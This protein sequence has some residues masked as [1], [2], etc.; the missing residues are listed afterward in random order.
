MRIYQALGIRKFVLTIETNF[1][2]T[3]NLL[4]RYSLYDTI[5]MSNKLGDRNMSK[6]ATKEKIKLDQIMKVLFKLSK[7]VMINLLNGLFDE[8]YDYRKVSIEYSNSEFVD[9]DFE[10]LFGDMFITVRA[11]ES[12]FSYHIEFQTLN[13]NSMAI[14]MFRYGFEKAVERAGYEENEEITLFYPKQLVIFLEENKNIKDEIYF[15]LRLP[16]EQEIRFSVPVMKYWKYSAE[17][18]KDKK[19]YALLPLQVFKSRKKIKSIYDSSIS[20]EDKA[21]LINEEFKGLIVVIENT[22]KV[23]EELYNGEEIICVDLEKILKVLANISE[24]LY[25]KYG[26]YSDIG[27]EVENMVTTLFDPVVKKEVKMEAKA[28]A[29]AEVATNMLKEKMDIDLIVRLTGLTKEEVLKIKKEIELQA[30]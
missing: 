16:Y 2:E 3:S 24:Y 11:N 30:E 14:R 4:S 29:K 27:K 21:R 25:K 18:L 1:F 5:Y 13:D 9:D 26:E 12:T 28:E 20:Y 8:N 6:I 10:R 7:K 17:D 23:L 15:K 22:I 19:M